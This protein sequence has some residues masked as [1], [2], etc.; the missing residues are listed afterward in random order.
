LPLVDEGATGSTAMLDT[1][2]TVLCDIRDTQH[3][4][5]P[6]EL[7]RPQVVFHAAALQ[8]LPLPEEA[9]GEAI[10][11]NEWDTPDDPGG[12]RQD[13]RGAVREHLHR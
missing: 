9:P 8:H 13:R 6:F 4:L 1:D 5:D 3:V 7:R 12:R 2:E 11:T 10:K